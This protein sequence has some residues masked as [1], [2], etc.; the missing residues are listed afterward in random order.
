M[1]NL[2]FLSIPIGK[3]IEINLEFGAKLKSPPKIFGVNYFLRG[4]DGKFLNEKNDK[5]VWLKW[6]EKRVHGELK[7]IKTPIGYVPL[8]DDLKVLFKEH[9][10]KD[11][12]YEDYLKQFTI[13]VNEN[14]SKIERLRKIYSELKFVPQTVFKLY[15]EEEARLKEAQVKFGDYIT[16]D[17]FEVA[18]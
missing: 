1:S 7:A 14:L 13:R 5:K 15:N 11:Y 8:Y 3:Y 6:M 4:A 18:A 12:V 9:L 10:N 2:D 17:K 16:P